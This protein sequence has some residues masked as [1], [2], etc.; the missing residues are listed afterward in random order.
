MIELRVAAGLTQDDL[1]KRLGC[2]RRTVIRLESGDGGIT[3]AIEA[4]VR[5]LSAPVA[6]AG[7]VVVLRPV[8]ALKPWQEMTT[9]ERE[10]LPPGSPGWKYRPGSWLPKGRWEETLDEPQTLKNG[11]VCTKILWGSNGVGLPTMNLIGSTRNADATRHDNGFEPLA[12]GIYRPM[13]PNQGSAD[14]LGKAKK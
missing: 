6:E 3:E 5:S 9:E 7:E 11:A 4:T 12:A 14:F 8:P 1:A 13:K 2:S 10:M